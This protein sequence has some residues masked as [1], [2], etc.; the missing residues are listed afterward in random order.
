MPK[1]NNITGAELKERA[2]QAR[3]Q[4]SEVG[5]NYAVLVAKEHP[6]F[7]RIERRTKLYNVARGI[8]IDEEITLILEG[9]VKRFC[10]AQVA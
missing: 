8:V 6:D 2:V 9:L 1:E 7:A 5:I 4:L 10:S 3:K